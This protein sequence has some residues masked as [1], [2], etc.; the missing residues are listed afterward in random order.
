[1]GAA[2]DGLRYRG[3]DVRGAGPLR[4]QVARGNRLQIAS[5]QVQVWDDDL[6]IDAWT[7]CALLWDARQA[8]R[9]PEWAEVVR[10]TLRRARAPKGTEQARHS[11]E[12]GGDAA[13]D[14][15]RQSL[16]VSVRAPADAA[17]DFHVGR[18]DE[19]QP[20]FQ[21][22]GDLALWYTRGDLGPVTMPFAE[23]LM[24]AMNQ[25]QARALSAEALPRWQ[26]T[27]TKLV[28]RAGLKGRFEWDLEWVPGPG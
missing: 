16:R 27:V 7:A 3:A 12:S 28:A 22:A 20:Y 4:D 19:A 18:F 26:E 25:L 17:L 23:V 8:Y 2:T 6:V 21:R 10:A 5:A 1:V 24:A 14:S 13:G 11:R 9:A 15:E